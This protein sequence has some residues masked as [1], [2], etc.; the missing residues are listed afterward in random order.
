MSRVA[1]LT[2]AELAT[3]NTAIPSGARELIK[4]LAAEVRELTQ[5]IERRDAETAA[6]LAEE[7]TKQRVDHYRQ[8]AIKAETKLKEITQ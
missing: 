7:F 5:D 1:L 2:A 6:G 3:T 4:A 8:R